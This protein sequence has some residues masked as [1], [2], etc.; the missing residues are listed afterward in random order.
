MGVHALALL[1]RS[2]EGFPSSYIAASVNTHPVFTR[3]V[4]SLLVKAGLVE[5]REGRDGGYR[6]AR[7]ADSI[8]LADVYRIMRGEGPFP[9]SPNDPSPLCEVGSGVRRAMAEIAETAE[10]RLV[11]DL[12]T[13]TIAEVSERA[14]AL[15]NFPER[16]K[17]DNRQPTT[18]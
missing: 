12:A 6:L 3:K 9:L 13:H 4:L 17:G 14:V 1:A 10:E 16:G 18:S 8:T 11:R 7:A 15:G 2:P 5:T